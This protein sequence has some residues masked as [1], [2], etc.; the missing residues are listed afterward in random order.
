MAPNNGLDLGQAERRPASM[1]T[2]SL[3][4]VKIELSALV[5]AVRNTHEEIV[6]TKNRSPAAVLISSGEDESWKETIAVRSDPSLMSEIQKGLKELRE[7]RA[8]LYTLDE[9]VG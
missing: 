7:R 1:K 4:E 9:W 2:L 6:I 8:R 3:S 5:E